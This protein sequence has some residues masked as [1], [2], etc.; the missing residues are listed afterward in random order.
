V[1]WRDCPADHDALPAY[2]APVGTP[3]LVVVSGPAG[4]GKSTLAR[5]LGRAV[6]CPVVSRDEIKE[7]MVAATPGHVPAAGDALTLATYQLFFETIVLLLR[8]GVTVVAEAGFQHRLWAPG[9]EPLAGIAEL[10]VVRCVVPAEVARR[11]G[12][13]RMSTDPARAAHADAE[14]FAVPRSFE[15]LDLDVATLDV[16]TADGWDPALEEVAAFCRPGWSP[17]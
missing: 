2:A 6:P 8:G 1:T 15:P 4:S 9:L 3:T 17:R 12:L 13:E 11:R 16:R 5:A 14:W 10:K 7:G